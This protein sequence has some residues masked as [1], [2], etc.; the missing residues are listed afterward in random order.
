MPTTL[1]DKSCRGDVLARARMSVDFILVIKGFRL[2]LKAICLNHKGCTMCS[3]CL[4]ISLVEQQEP[5]QF[6]QFLRLPSSA[7]SLSEAVELLRRIVPGSCSILFGADL[8]N[9]LQLASQ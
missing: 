1:V 5:W 9:A 8:C 2:A 4:S 6:L 7:Q 3:M